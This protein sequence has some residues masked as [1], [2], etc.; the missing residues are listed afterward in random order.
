MWYIMTANKFFMNYR[1]LLHDI[2]FTNDIIRL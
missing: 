1:N 2:Y